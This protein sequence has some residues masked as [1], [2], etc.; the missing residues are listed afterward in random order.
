[1]TTFDNNQKKDLPPNSNEYPGK[2]FFYEDK[3]LKN[4][5]KEK[6]LLSE[7]KWLEKEKQSLLDKEHKLLSEEQSLLDKEHKLLSEEQL[8]LYEEQLFSIQEQLSLIDDKLRENEKEE[9]SLLYE[10]KLLDNALQERLLL[11]FVYADKCRENALEIDFMEW[12]KQTE[13]KIRKIM[14]TAMEHYDRYSNG[15]AWDKK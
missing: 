5:L 4:A 15:G 11:L 14:Y 6:F 10:R 13:R 1:M 12:L 3:W 8:L 9:E 7:R 2:L